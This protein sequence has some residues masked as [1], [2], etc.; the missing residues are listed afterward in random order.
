MGKFRIFLGICLVAAS[1]HIEVIYP[2]RL[3]GNNY[4]SGNM[5]CV[6]NRAK[7]FSFNGAKW[8]ARNYCDAMV[9]LLSVDRLM[10]IT[11]LTKL[12]TGKF[13]VAAFCF[14]KTKHIGTVCRQ[15]M[16]DLREAE[17]D[18]I[19]IPG[20]DLQF[21]GDGSGRDDGGLL[22]GTKPKRAP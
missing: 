11:N 20:R 16:G 6:A 12:R 13:A 21:Q 10:F 18:G 15:E 9:S 4:G 2:D 8:Q 1:W 22:R 14:L 7:I 17:P 5:P 19:D 3:A